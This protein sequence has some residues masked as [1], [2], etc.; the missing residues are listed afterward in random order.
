M[1]TYSRAGQFGPAAIPGAPRGVAL[2]VVDASGSD[3]VLYRDA[4]KN[5]TTGPIVY[6]SDGG[7]VTFFADPGTYTVKW[8][9]GQAAVTIS[10]GTEEASAGGGNFALTVGL[11][12]VSSGEEVL[13]RINAAGAATLVSGTIHLA[14]FTARKTET[15]G[16]L[17]SLAS[18]TASATI[19]TAKMGVYSV[20]ADGSLTRVATTANDTALWGTTFTAF[21]KA[22]TAPWA[23]VAG[24][25]YAFA[26]IAVG[27]T[28]PQ[29]AAAS[30]NFADAGLAP[31]IA[32]AV[33]GQSD[34][35][36]T[37]AAGS[38]ADDFRMIQ[39]FVLP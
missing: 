27:S 1:P 25:R 32:A 39:G 21:T 12:Y 28:M 35:P 33:S 16:N 22:T 4:S 23:K 17:R 29:I 34:L 38:I 2:R 20:A 31:R 11:S 3:A 36:A 19:T 6:S 15:I 9:G 24:N 10:G 18:G 5:V 30:I 26:A 7:E 8:T 37:I 13:P 14:Y